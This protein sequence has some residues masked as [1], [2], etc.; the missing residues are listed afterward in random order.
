MSTGLPDGRVPV[1]LSAHAD[2]LVRADAEAILHYLDRTPDV[3]EVAATLLRTRRIRRHRAV[4]RAADIDELT[5]GLRAVSTGD[6]HPLVVRS[7]ETTTA[8]TCFVFPGQGG[9]WPSMGAD[10]YRMMTVYRAQADRCAQAFVSAGRLSPVNY[11]LGE[12]APEHWSQ[13]EIQGA[14]FTHAVALAALWRS[15]GIVPDLTVGHSLGEIAAAYVAGSISLA[16]AAAVVIARATAVERLQGDYG[17]AVLGCPVDDVERLIASTPGWLEVSAVNSTSSV[18]VSGDRDAVVTLVADASAGGVFA[19]Q[20]DVNYPGHTSALD[21]VRDEL[22]PLLPHGQFADAPV[23]F[24]GSATGA[25]VPSG[26]DFTDYWLSNLRDTVRFDRAVDAAR[27]Q[28]AA[29][30]IE[31]SPHPTL[32]LAIDELT[33]PDA[34]G[35][36]VGSGSRDDPLVESLAAGIVTA[37][38]TDPGYRWAGLI[39]VD[40]PLLRNFPNAPMRDI[41][42]WADPTPLRTPDVVTTSHEAWLPTTNG[43]AGQVRRVAV[44]DLPGPGSPLGAKLRE[45]VAAHPGAEPCAPGDADL[46]IAVAP[47]LDHPDVVVAA[48]EIGRL[49]DDGL[50]TYPNDT[51]CRELCLVTV[52]GE[53]V[54][55]GEP[56]A[57]PAQSALAA[58]HRCIGFEHHDRAFGHLDLPSWD[59]DDATASAALDA[60][61]GGVHEAALRENASGPC[62]FFHTVTEAAEPSAQWSDSVYDD[63][64]ITGGSGAVGMHFARYAAERGARR[65]VLLSRGGIDA[66]T[67]AE[68]AGLQPGVEIVAP[69]CDLGSDDDVMAAAQRFGADGASLLIH[70]AGAA[71]FADGDALTA[72]DFTETV[73]AK[74]TGLARL[75]DA[76][77]LRADARILLCS[78][79]S[80]V[81]GGRTHAA[82]AAAN[83]MLD[84]IA[85]QL[86]AKGQQCVAV[87]YGLWRADPLRPSRITERAGVASIERSGLLP[88]PPGEAVAASMC[89]HTADPLIMSADADR[90]RLFLESR[91][92]RDRTPAAEEVS[93]VPTRIR[94]ELAAVLKLDAK[95][96][97]LTMSLLDLGLDSLLALDLRTRLLKATGTKVPL[98]TLLGG[99]TGAA[100]IDDLNTPEHAQKVETTR[101]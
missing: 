47:L 54:Q 43:A 82:Y 18:V 3:A 70:A 101:D 48:Q 21:R 2:D 7:A 11:I 19:R 88:M 8:R 92:I 45:A 16:D 5:S 34:Q 20:L 57:L 1:V 15:Y 14:Q 23:Q 93:D 42:L 22:L 50:L 32:L 72:D 9:Q 28:G 64:I 36:V 76:W 96:I 90:L 56:V 63:V 51:R 35:L 65:I 39:D 37:A 62:L 41:R 85:G 6:D 86:R 17:M 25:A 13:V 74:V 10:G 55:P 4:V 75:T 94:A 83:R 44:I 38:I 78:S 99:V 31:M 59:I 66:S 100:L 97:D 27:T 60:V 40:V 61:L 26:V 91:D 80:G 49:I 46:V 68:L 87:R 52:G 53:H 95:S 73:T 67:A 29:A 71:A 33:G 98:A 79:V 77:P 58:M 12:N 84:V 30:F 69:A 24:I 89:D 81:W